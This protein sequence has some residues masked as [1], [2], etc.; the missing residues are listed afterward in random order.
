MLSREYR[1]RK[2]E[3]PVKK[4]TTSKS[5]T[6][7]NQEALVA[8]WSL[9]ILLDLKAW[10]QMQ[11]RYEGFTSSGEILTCVG[12]GHLEDEELT[13]KQFLALLEKQRKKYRALSPGPNKRL[14]RNSQQIARYLGLNETERQLLVFAAILEEDENF[15]EVT[16]K[17]G[18]LNAE[19]ILTVLSNL[20]ELP[21]KKIRKALSRH[22]LLAKSGLLDL[23]RSSKNQIQYKIDLLD[24]LAEALQEA[25][26]SVEVML[27]KYFV[28]SRA[29]KLT[30]EN[31][32]YVQE[33]LIL[34]RDH[35][36]LACEKKIQGVNILIYGAPGTGKTEF[37]KTIAGIIDSRLYEIKL[38]DGD[39]FFSKSKRMKSFQL[40]QQVLVR[41]KNSL[42]LFDEVD[43]LLAESMGFFLRDGDS[44]NLKAW[45]NNQL[46]D[47]HVPTIWIANDIR[48]AES[49][50][51]RR[52]D[53]VLHL[54][55]P[56]RSVRLEIIEKYLR[57]IQVRKSWKENLAENSELAPAV[58]ATAARVIRPRKKQSS[59]DTEKQ[60]EKL[61]RSTLT[62]MGH[63][64]QSVSKHD[65]QIPY[66]LEAL[67][68]D[69]NLEAIVSG[70][71]NHGEGRLC[72]YG[73]PGTGKT[74][75]ARYLA[76][77]LDKPLL[78][79]RG[80]DLLGPYVGQTEANIAAAFQEAEYEKAVLLLDEAD[81][82]LRERSGSHQSWEVTQVNE[83][84]TRME[85]YN[86][87][88]ICSTN[89]M[90]TLD[91]ASLR[92]F[93]VK[94][95]FDYL[96]PEQTW[97]FFCRVCPEAEKKEKWK[98]EWQD[99]LTRLTLLT[100]GDFA[101]VVR[102]NRISGLKSSPENVLKGLAE[103]VAF[104]D[105]SSNH[106]IGFLVQ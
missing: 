74:E 104:K 21:R 77:Q 34:I 26:A 73:P 57:G 54:D 53:I 20:L 38:G 69:H 23:G 87:V 96:R 28:P 45:I 46:E 62:A 56:P 7:H 86:G 70:L 52:F 68:P 90:E 40:A 102:K 41:R 98:K 37:A 44:L 29:G 51:I 18:E 82:F 48:F 30:A 36:G 16:D 5:V 84:L 59:A 24:G 71:R 65:S 43:N 105:A 47:N 83:L 100:P 61:L 64:W 63:P 35:L 81:S 75:F 2:V 79:K 76:R 17:L 12:L 3:V 13:K 19:G 88:F 39:E 50:Y 6:G 72:L 93:D 25:D 8:L 22:G 99:R 4:R 11:G 101:T 32:R 94:I 10:K 49:S 1:K 31:Y 9:K 78:L 85:Q 15:Q 58:I 91:G 33:H 89:L 106:R 67:N 97:K 95:K 66:L 92:R 60:L 80:A 14:D 55:T 42:I 27:Q 103:E